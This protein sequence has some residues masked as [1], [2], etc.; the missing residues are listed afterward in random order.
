M[1][2]KKCN[3]CGTSYEPLEKVYAWD[4][5]DKYSWYCSDHAGQVRAFNRQQEK[6]FYEHFLDVRHRENYLND[7][8][9]ELWEKVARK[10]R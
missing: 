4:K 8:Q 3:F 9:R 10:Y 6:G 2:Y 5:E 1:E 7:N